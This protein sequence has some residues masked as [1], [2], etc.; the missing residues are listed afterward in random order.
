MNWKNV[1]VLVTGGASFIGSHVVDVLVQH[2][3]KVRVIDNLSSGK[4]ENIKRHIQSH[5]IE[6]IK[7]D[8]LRPNI[9]NRSVK[10]VAYVFHLAAL[11]GGRG[12]VDTH[13]AACVKNVLLDSLLIESSYKAGVKQFTFASSGCV[14]PNYLQ[15]DIHKDIYLSEGMVGPPYEP[16]NMYGWAK[17]TTEKALKAYAQDYGMR[18]ASCRFFTVYGDRGIENHAVIAMIARAFIHQNPFEI[19]GDG[20]QIRN[21]THV[22]DIVS[23]MIKA[24]ERIHDGSAINLGTMERTRV[25]DAA[26]IICDNFRYSPDFLFQ[27]N[28]PTGP[29][30]R[31][32]DNRKAKEL[33]NW[34]PKTS[35]V[36]G[37]KKTIIWYRTH[38]KQTWVHQNL[39]VLLMERN[40]H[41]T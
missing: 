3:A 30:N 13:Q 32:C 8:L 31:I 20:T 9:T 21:W 2:G 25:I 15:R 14:Y 11:H 16:D 10:D 17:L 7:G 39:P 40:I 38:K 27:K 28:M 1:P 12:Y 5:A 34:E 36:E 6:F 22:D 18:C 24:A 19:W 33:L 23:G 41:K 4:R 26:K 37:V 35:F 29:I